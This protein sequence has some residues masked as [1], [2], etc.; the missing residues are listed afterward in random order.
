[1]MNS[2]CSSSSYSASFTSRTNEPYPQLRHN[3]KMAALWGGLSR[4]L[5]REPL[6]SL[7]FRYVRRE[8]YR[9]KHW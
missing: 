9:R 7:R 4:T 6:G 5:Y 8:E 2:L 3:I 1:M